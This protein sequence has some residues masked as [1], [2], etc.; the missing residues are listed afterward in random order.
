MAIVADYFKQSELAFAAY[1]NLSR[2]TPVV[3]ELLDQGRGMSLAQR[4]GE[5]IRSRQQGAA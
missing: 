3:A 5:S 4:I 2:G 1:I